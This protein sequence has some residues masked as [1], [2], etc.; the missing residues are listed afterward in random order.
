MSHLHPHLVSESETWVLDRFFSAS[1]D[2]AQV[3]KEFISAIASSPE[4][5]DKIGQYFY[6]KTTELVSTASY[7]L[8]NTN[9]NSVNIVGD[10]LKLVPVYWAAS[11]IV[12]ILSSEYQPACFLTVFPSGRYNAQGKTTSIRCLHSPRVVQYTR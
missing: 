11:E 12:R 2:A 10:V 1:A 6:K 5:V 7:S 3:Q 9:T 8:I 4:V